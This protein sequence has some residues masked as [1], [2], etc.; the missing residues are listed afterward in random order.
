MNEVKIE[1][2][3]SCRSVPRKVNTKRESAWKMQNC[4]F[5]CTRGHATQVR[6]KVK[7]RSNLTARDR[8][9]CVERC[10]YVQFTENRDRSQRLEISHSSKR[11]TKKKDLIATEPNARDRTVTK[12]CSKEPDTQLNGNTPDSTWR[13]GF[14]T[15]SKCYLNLPPQEHGMTPTRMLRTSVRNQQVQECCKLVVCG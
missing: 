9:S 5:G 7:E 12:N 14:D 11:S 10:V 1:I 2:N 15:Q 6:F 3:T 13:N 4:A 8:S